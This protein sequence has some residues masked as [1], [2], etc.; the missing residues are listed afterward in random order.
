MTFK[1]FLLL[2]ENKKAYWKAL[3]WGMSFAISYITYLATDN[4]VAWAV[5]ALP[6]AK[7]VSE[8]LT[9]YFN[10]AYIGFKK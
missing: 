5:S 4:N 7:I 2:D 10:D 1:E 3:N 6:I 9:R 8:M